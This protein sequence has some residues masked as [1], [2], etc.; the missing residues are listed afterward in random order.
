MVSHR[1]DAMRNMD[2]VCVLV[3]DG[4]AQAGTY[5]ELLQQDGAFRELAEG[6]I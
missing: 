6:E 2:T 1:L 4:I 5:K 3:D